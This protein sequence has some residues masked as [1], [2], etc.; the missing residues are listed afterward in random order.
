MFLLFLNIHIDFPYS[1]VLNYQLL[2]S[3]A[4]IL[5]QTISTHLL[6]IIIKVNHTVLV[7][8]FDHIRYKISILS[9]LVN[10]QQTQILILQIKVQMQLQYLLDL[11]TNYC[12]I[13]FTNN[14]FMGLQFLLHTWNDNL[15]T[16]ETS[17]KQKYQ[18]I[19]S[20][21]KTIVYFEYRTS[22]LISHRLQHHINICDRNFTPLM[23]SFFNISFF[24]HRHTYEQINTLPT[25]Y[26]F[27]ISH[28]L[29]SILLATNTI[30]ITKT[31]QLSILGVSEL[32]DI[33]E[34][35]QMDY[36]GLETK[37]VSI[38]KISNILKIALIHTLSIYIVTVIQIVSRK[39]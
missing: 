31:I 37:V 11:S 17:I 14:I 22:S 3:F 28:F 23:F 16:I 10:I 38:Q 24:Y 25:N 5:I 29:I 13:V 27:Y 18:F 35:I 1:I 26:L 34:W 4:I 2:N 7:K 9:K 36:F 12:P 33:V 20:M 15:Q 21:A 30:T 19:S 32:T 39:Y 8:R 6:N